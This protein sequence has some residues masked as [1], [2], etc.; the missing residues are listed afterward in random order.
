MGRVL[1]E[2]GKWEINRRYDV[3]R[4]LRKVNERREPNKDAKLLNLLSDGDKIFCVKKSDTVV[5][6]EY[7]WL[8]N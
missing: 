5:A 3:G 6:W 4:A 2:E 8:E 7:S 1:E